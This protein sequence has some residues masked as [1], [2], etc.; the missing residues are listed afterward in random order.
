ML[1]ASGWDK[2]L[3]SSPRYFYDYDLGRA[4]KQALMFDLSVRPF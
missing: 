2:V 1:H 3:F 4:L